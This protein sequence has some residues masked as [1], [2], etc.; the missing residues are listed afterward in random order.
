MDRPPPGLG[1]SGDFDVVEVA[2][3]SVL[4]I[5]LIGFLYLI[6]NHPWWALL[7]VSALLALGG[8]LLLALWLWDPAEKSEIEKIG[9]SH[10]VDG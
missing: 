2:A 3:P 4:I 5:I 10:V 1:G 6:V 8:V 7:A 9:G